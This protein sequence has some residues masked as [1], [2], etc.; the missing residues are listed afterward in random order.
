MQTI[1]NRIFSNSISYYLVNIISILLNTFY[2]N[3]NI[4]FH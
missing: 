1:N 4:R 3:S 2:Y